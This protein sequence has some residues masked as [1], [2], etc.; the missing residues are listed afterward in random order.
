M[1]QAGWQ[2]G[3]IQNLISL[4]VTTLN[5]IMNNVWWN[6]LA[7]IPKAVWCKCNEKKGGEAC[8]I[9]EYT[10]GRCFYLWHCHW[11]CHCDFVFCYSLVFCDEAHILSWITGRSISHFT[12]MHFTFLI[13][14]FCLCILH[15]TFYV[16]DCHFAFWGRVQW[17]ASF[18]FDYREGARG[19]GIRAGGTW[20]TWGREG[21]TKASSAIQ[22]RQTHPPPAAGPEG[23]GT[24]NRF[25]KK[26]CSLNF[27]L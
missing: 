4:N 2:N 14:Y 12:F 11:H 3:K 20:G 25:H 7:A 8:I 5:F 22:M 10:E 19:W 1:R 17:G 18:V 27:G 6:L 24:Q 13:A 16:L 9:F 21:W 26:W 23:R 15:F